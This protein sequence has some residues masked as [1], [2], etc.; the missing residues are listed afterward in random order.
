MSKSRKRDMGK[1][2]TYAKEWAKEHP[3]K[4]R[5][6]LRK[7]YMART[8]L[9]RAF[10]DQPCADCGLRYPDH[11]MQFDHIVPNGKKSLSGRSTMSLKKLIEELAEC[12]VVCA[13]CHCIR[14]FQRGQLR[15]GSQGMKEI[16]NDLSGS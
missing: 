8:K 13:N 5:A 10:K 11:V 14:T 7:L 3:G 16:L 4:V 6:S 9:L 1:K 12:E 2:R 15:Q